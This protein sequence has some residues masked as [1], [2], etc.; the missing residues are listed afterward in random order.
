MDI[1]PSTRPH[2]AVN[3][4]ETLVSLRAQVKKDDEL[5]QWQQLADRELAS[6]A[7]FTKEGEGRLQRSSSNLQTAQAADER[8]RSE[9]EV[10]HIKGLLDQLDV[11]TGRLTAARRQA[12][13]RASITASPTPVMPVSSAAGAPKSKTS[14][15]TTVTVVIVSALVL[16]V[17]AGAVISSWPAPSSRS[18][19]NSQA[20]PPAAKSSK[21]VAI[22]LAATSTPAA[23][24][25]GE[26]TPMS[27]C[28]NMRDMTSA[29]WQDYFMK[30]E[31][32][33]VDHW[34]G[35]VLGG[36]CAGLEI[37]HR[38]WRNAGRGAAGA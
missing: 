22:A 19:G 33:R 36:R 32:K 28:D 24:Y 6:L 3:N 16:L 12:A 2:Q 8:T 9:A 5:A 18:A 29:Q 15:S 23:T 13:S 4:A 26:E 25:L 1:T 21:P 31:G 30:L 35:W 17:V 7:H 38:L 20:M 27:I 14:V 10:T 11:A 37:L 34:T